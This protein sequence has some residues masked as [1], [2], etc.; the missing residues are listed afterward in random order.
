M[1]SKIPYVNDVKEGIRNLDIEETTLYIKTTK[2]ID[3]I[4]N[5]L[6]DLKCFVIKKVEESEISLEARKIITDGSG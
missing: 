4:S 6:S 2:G 5:K 1:I 3:Y